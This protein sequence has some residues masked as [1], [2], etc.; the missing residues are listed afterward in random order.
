MRYTN[1]WLVA[2]YEQIQLS[3]WQV[4]SWMN[5]QQS[6][7]LLLKVDPLSTIPISITLY[8]IRNLKHQPSWEFLYRIHRRCLQLK[9]RYTRYRYLFLLFRLLCKIYSLFCSTRKVDYIC[10]KKI[11]LWRCI[12]IKNHGN[13][14][15]LAHVQFKT[16]TSYVFTSI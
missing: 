14:L 8:K 2:K 12:L 15:L 16:V 5:E 1:P 3:T 9:R 6:Q 10:S 13:N 7:N 11:L 4:G